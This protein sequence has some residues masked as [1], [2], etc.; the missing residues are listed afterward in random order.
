MLSSFNWVDY[1]ILGIFLVSMLLGLARGF[2][3]E[4]ISLIALIAAFTLAT[5]FAS[6]LANMLSHSATNATDSASTVGAAGYVAIA[7][8]YTLIFLGTLLI[9]AIINFIFN[10]AIKRGALSFGNRLMGA[11]FGLARGF[12]FNIVLI[13]L[14]QFTAMGN[15]GAWHDS[16]LVNKLQPAVNWMSSIVSPALANLKEKYGS[17]IDNVN[18]KIKNVTMPSGESSE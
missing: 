6:P 5:M 12:I 14:V 10:V 17:T 2:V 9:G 16:Q 15:E 1:T 8:A 7:V 4:I 11:V 13:F 18:T 3:K